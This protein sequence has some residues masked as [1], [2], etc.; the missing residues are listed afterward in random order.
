MIASMPDPRTMETEL[1]SLGVETDA[2]A[3]ERLAH[4]AR[5]IQERASLVNL[6]GPSELPRLWSR[7]MLESASYSL[8]LDMTLPVADIGSGAGFPGLV[9]AVLGCRRT[10]L[11]EPRRKRRLFLAHAVSSLGLDGVCIA[12]GRVQDAGPFQPCTQFT[13]RAVA[14][15]AIL[16]RM[17]APICGDGS[18]LV[19]RV[20]AESE[21]AEGFAEAIHLPSPPLD[22]QGM[23]V[24]YR[25]SAIHDRIQPRGEPL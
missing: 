8:L 5:L 11:I 15:P 10:T 7:H 14:P 6:I 25:L 9:L 17:I 22:R 2:E 20:S 3:L 19:C 18:T 13:A 12:P 16:L 4:L 24:Q 21:A 1:R 23:L